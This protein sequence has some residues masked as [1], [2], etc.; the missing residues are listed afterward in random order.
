MLSSISSAIPRQTF[1]ERTLVFE[2]FQLSVEEKLEVDVLEKNIRSYST[3]TLVSLATSTSNAG[4][5]Y[6]L[7]DYSDLVLVLIA[8][9]NLHPKVALSI[10]NRLSMLEPLTF[11]TPWVTRVVN[12][13]ANALIKQRVVANDASLMKCAWEVAEVMNQPNI[14]ANPTGFAGALLFDT[15]LLHSSPAHDTGEVMSV[16]TLLLLLSYV[17][18]L[19]ESHVPSPLRA[20]S[21]RLSKQRGE[22]IEVWVKVNMPDYAGLPLPWILKVLDLY[23]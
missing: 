9:K 5:Q 21:V 20:L 1:L 13:A 12:M 7:I 17:N 10:V 16:G 6:T 14:A 18:K 19:D 8:N 3:P 11:R 22:E 4:V 15:L 23:V 2:S